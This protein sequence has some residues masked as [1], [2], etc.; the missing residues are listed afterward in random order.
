MP[1][2]GRFCDD[3]LTFLD[4]L[5]RRPCVSKRELTSQDLFDLAWKWKKAI[6]PSSMQGGATGWRRRATEE[7]IKDLTSLLFECG[8]EDR[9][10]TF[11]PEAEEDDK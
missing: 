3:R 11:K 1:S 5:L 2:V 4:L 9:T 8:F 6:G 10:G 7:C